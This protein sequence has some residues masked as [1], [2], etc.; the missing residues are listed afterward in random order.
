MFKKRLNKLKRKLVTVLSLAMV[1]SGFP[2]VPCEAEEAQTTSTECEMFFDNIE[3]TKL[4]YS[5]SWSGEKVWFLKYGNYGK[6]DPYVEGDSE[7][8]INGFTIHDNYGVPTWYPDVSS[9]SLNKILIVKNTY[10]SPVSTGVTSASLA[11]VRSYLEFREGAYGETKP[12]EGTYIS[13]DTTVNSVVA[14][15]AK[16]DKYSDSDSGMLYLKE[17]DENP[18]EADVYASGNASLILFDVAANAKC[19]LYADK[20]VRLYYIKVM[21]E[22]TK[23]SW[24]FT[25]EKILGVFGNILK[26]VKVYIDGLYVDL[27]EAEY[28]SLNRVQNGGCE[29]EGIMYVP[30]RKGK[31]LYL[32]GSFGG[33]ISVN[34]NCYYDS[35]DGNIVIGAEEAK[36]GSD[37]E[38]Y[39]RIEASLGT[40]L[41]KISWLIP[42][43][44]AKTDLNL[45]YT[46]TEQEGV[47]KGAGYTLYTKDDDID[48]VSSAIKATSAG[49]YYAVA[50]LDEGYIWSDGSTEDKIIYWEIKKADIPDKAICAPT[51]KTLTYTGN[52][53]E[54]VNAGSA[55]EGGVEIGTMYYAVTTGDTVPEESAYKTSIPSATDVGSY[56]VWY[57]VIG[58]KNHN[59]NNSET[60][61][62]N[63]TIAKPENNNIN[64]SMEGWTYGDEQ[65]S[66][67]VTGLGYATADITYSNKEDGT[68]TTEKPLTPGTWYVKASV[69]ETAN[70]PA[71]EAVDD[72]EITK[73]NIT[74]TADSDS[75]AYDGTA[76]TKDSY[77]CSVNGLATGDKIDKITVTGSQTA[78]GSSNNVPSEAVIKNSDNTDVTNCYNITYA[79]GTLTVAK[80]PLQITA[81]AK[82]KKFGESDP[83]LTYTSEGLVEN[84]KITGTLTRTAGENAGTYAIT[85]GTLTAGDNYEISFVG[86]DLTIEK[87][88][89]ISGAPEASKSVD[90]TVDTVGKVELPDNWTWKTADID[91]ELTVGA[92][93]E[94]IAEYTG[95][96]KDNYA[97]T[98]KYV[99]VSITRNACTH[100]NLEDKS[101]V[102]ASC[103]KEGILA[104][105]KCPVCNKLFVKDNDKLVE[106]A[107]D[108]L[109]IEAVGHSY[110][111]AT[112]S[113]SE[114]H[115][116]CT[117]TKV[118][119]REGCDENSEGHVVTET[120]NTTSETTPAGCE[121]KGVITYTATFTDKD[122]GTVTDSVDIAAKKH[123]YVI[124]YEWSEDGKTCTAT[125]VCK[126]DSTHK[127]TETARYEL[128]KETSKIKATVKETATTEK[129]GTTAYTA[130]FDNKLFTAQ[131]KDV[132]DIPKVEKTAD[133]PATPVENKT[134]TVVKEEGTT[135]PVADNKAEVVVTSKPGEEPSVAYKGTTDES[136]KAVEIPETVVSNGVTYAVTEISEGAFENNKAVESVK[137][138]DNITTLGENAFAGC[139]NLKSVE[140]SKNIKELPEGTF[141]DCTSLKKVDIPKNVKKIGDKT[142][143][144]CSKLATMNLKNNVTEIGEKAFERCTSLKKVTL[145][146]NVTK[147]GS[148][149]FNGAKKL[150][151]IT[152][153]SKK[154]TKKSVKG[155]FK[156][157]KINTIKV[158]T[159]SKAQNKKLVKKYK[160]I[161]TKKNAGRKVTIK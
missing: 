136:A 151:E 65:T 17:G 145:G 21:P 9:N 34:D 24:D 12:G 46:G 146:K 23:E 74:I 130:T 139:T 52:P 156:G 154:F 96:D 43:E 56:N 19:K 110:G 123:D 120:V 77:T 83:E 107:A 15:V 86:A 159:G 97:D 1:L 49:E 47:E 60:Q 35:S 58:D 124:T 101:E 57:K 40:T 126:N 32:N 20:G 90:Y 131:T 91:K 118:C 70:Y 150:K 69:A 37:K 67:K 11:E 51:A 68:Y 149:A 80:R 108:E 160:K 33:R 31:T 140:L 116:T 100:D 78:V 134:T 137:L 147:I 129:M 28:N 158:D 22:S 2:V 3:E 94:A 128:D 155:A 95:S 36:T 7:L 41:N 53:Q 157:S 161:F 143:S 112:Y 81:V 18:K 109:K 44:V 73:R 50:K 121:E 127:I 119:V 84:D 87:A 10:T 135:I 72:F 71:G 104:H 48:G 111:K 64:V 62:I 25:D 148:K 152:I 138:G 39:V 144:G 132:V 106:K 99:T 88:D 85:Q 93:V 113:W 114:D 4:T 61:K 55:K 75:K 6:G 59:Y 38:G 105:S 16:Y 63:V 45:I 29:F 76:L 42:T 8:K 82:S 66:P 125:A 30:F 79:N 142:F 5:Y 89:S 122:F 54:L 102:P 153:Q 115:S 14:V 141:K 133:T 13:F 98:A 27:T 103:I 92:A 117:A 26:G